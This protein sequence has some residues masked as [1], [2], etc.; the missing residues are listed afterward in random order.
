MVLKTFHTDALDGLCTTDQ[1]S[2]LDS[3]DTLRSQGISHYISLPQIIV[4]GDQSSGKSSVLEALSG[5]A[6]P[7][8]SNLCTRF[9]TELILRKNTRSSV[10]VSIVPHSSRVPSEKLAL[11]G[12]REQL[13]DFDGL[14]FLVERAKSAM[15]VSAH[16]K[17][18]SQDTLRVEVSGPDRPH[19]T[20]VD[21]PGLIHSETKQQ[22]AA[23]V[24][25]V[26]DVV[27]GYMEQRRSIILAVVSA[28]NDYANQVVLKLTRAAD[29]EGH[30][31]LGVITKPDTLI[32]GSG[33]EAMYG[34]HVLKNMDSDAGKF[35]LQDRNESE[36]QFFSQ[37]VWEK[38]PRAIL[39]VE[40]FRHRLSKLLLKQIVVEL[41]GLVAEIETK[42][43]A[44]EKSMA[45]LG[46]PRVTAVEQR[47]YL[48]HISQHFQ[49]LLKASVDGTY[50]D[51]FFGDAETDIGYKRRIRARMQN[52]NMDFADSITQFG[53][54]REIQESVTKA[55]HTGVGPIPITRE[56]FIDHVHYLMPRTRARE[57]PGTF[58][59]MIVAD[60]FREQSVPWEALAR[61]HIEKVWRA[62]RDFLF[63]VSDHIADESASAALY[64]AIFEPA[65]KKLLSDLNA[66]ASDLL[67]PHQSSHPITYNNHF[68]QALQEIRR[69]RN[70]ELFSQI[71]HSHFGTNGLKDP[72]KLPSPASLQ[73]LI[74]SLVT[75]TEPQMGRH[76]CS[77]ALDY[78]HAYYEVALERFIDD[79]AIEVVES[80]LIAPLTE[81]FSPISVT[82]MGKELVMQ[83]A[84]EP[85][86]S[87]VERAQLMRQV[88]VLQQGSV[89]LK[90]F[91]GVR[92]LILQG[93][94]MED[95]VDENA[96]VN[97]VGKGD[98]E[99][100]EG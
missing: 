17:A 69:K 77:E 80:K 31:T 65:L 94:E 45:R 90:K 63:H 1:L 37:G 18:F 62:V 14:P 64:Q 86:D 100:N 8:Q 55:R 5:V 46:K 39:G 95:S 67:K 87:R 21:L 79:M 13:D 59:P 9:P 50:N 57:L 51:E 49:T 52:L 38:L 82:N 70:L 28:K 73:P 76:E 42:S 74:D 23:D 20:I 7:V 26:Q 2:L 43:I 41:P 72:V 96:K 36:N 47:T 97:G 33:S 83:V 61:K 89:T 40:T 4:C 53:H 10:S 44:C 99:D 54:Y 27:R 93:A 32:P 3:I 11:S 88:D 85:E 60:L 34:W 30:R 66:K 56:A 35:S 25:L 91:I 81:F 98:A 16:G 24:E 84:G 12:F 22:S 48:I 6:F 71:V 15:G 78:M 19:L 58:N 75:H 29:K 68:V 92:R